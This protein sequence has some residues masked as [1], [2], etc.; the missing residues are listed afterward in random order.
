MDLSVC[1]Q[2]K[3]CRI[4]LEEFKTDLAQHAV[5]SDEL[6]SINSLSNHNNK[7]ASVSLLAVLGCITKV[8]TVYTF[9]D[10]C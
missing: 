6:T 5:V 9:N 1:G 8:L 4:Y 3:W 2:R 7:K 10:A